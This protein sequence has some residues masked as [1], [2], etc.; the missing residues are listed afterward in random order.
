VD[1]FAPGT[2]AFAPSSF[3]MHSTVP[4]GLNIMST[5]IGSDTAH[6]TLSGTSMAAPHT[7]GL[8]AYLLSLYPSKQFDPRFPTDIFPPTFTFDAQRAFSNPSSFSFALPAWISSSLPSWI[9]SMMPSSEA[10]DVAAPAAPLPTLT[11]V[12]L[13]RALIALAT[14][15]LLK[16]LPADTANVLVFNNATSD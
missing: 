14:H 13:K 3:G 10:G 12:Q 6:S 16:E 2:I 8:L 7:A 9:S 5:Y 1:V 15:G 11:P 4:T